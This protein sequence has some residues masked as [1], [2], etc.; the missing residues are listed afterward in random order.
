[1]SNPLPETVATFL[2]SPPTTESATAFATAAA[3]EAEAMCAALEK[4]KARAHLE[5]VSQVAADKRLKKAAKEALI[6]A[7]D[8]PSSG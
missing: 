7:L 2:A 8:G 4:E 6:G 3:S 1:M 5:A